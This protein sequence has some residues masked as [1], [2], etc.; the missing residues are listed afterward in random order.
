MARAISVSA[1]ALALAA[2]VAIVLGSGP[3][4]AVRIEFQ[5]A[6]QLVAGDRVEVGGIPVGTV[7]S[8][9]L[10]RDGAAQVTVALSGGRFTP[11]H[12]GT[13]A[14]IGTVGLSGVTN[15]FVALVPGPASAPAIA[16]GGVVPETDTT[17]IVDIDEV[18][19]AITPR[20]RGNI[21][22]WIQESAG[23]LHGTVRGARRTLAYAAAA[24]QRSGAFIGQVTADR[25][26]FSDLLSSGARTAAALAA[27]D[28]QLTAGVAATATALHAIARARGALA[29]AIA[30][31]PAALADGTAFL[32]QLR[33][34]LG[35]LD[36]VLGD[37]RPVAA[38]LAAVLRA[39][40]PV[41]ARTTP[42]LAKLDAILPA[43][44][45][46]LA[47]LPG[48]ARVAVP[49]LAEATTALDRA[50]PI[51]TGL[52]PYGED[53]L[54]GILHGYGGGSAENYD[55]NGQFSRIAL[56]LPAP[57]LLT[58]V[59]GFDAPQL[60][61]H[62]LTGQL[63]KCPGSAAE[64]APDRSNVVTVAGCDRRQSP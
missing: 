4:Y 26:A 18:L 11:L 61:P 31:A 22:R 30:R 55:A 37:A 40:Q 58:S 50:L 6:G 45:G 59:L 41:S 33:P 9:S 60:S 3:G 21:R 52:R 44:D 5:D 46:A 38:P 19:D 36:P 25:A 43:L 34:T 35:A 49:A 39:L 14:S 29:D 8:L 10:S 28:R 54:L 1:V 63:A 16:S 53:I 42:V 48:L 27:P 12:R 24:L 7:S 23:V 56:G 20:V 15:R 13:T 62:F 2:V 64:P 51:F 32:D 57:T 47:E 17:P